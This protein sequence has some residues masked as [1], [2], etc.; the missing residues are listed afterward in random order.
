MH[1]FIR[2]SQ[3]ALIPHTK[4]SL[5]TLSLVIHAQPTHGTTLLEAINVQ[6]ASVTLDTRAILEG[7][8]NAKVRQV[9][10]LTL[11]SCFRFRKIS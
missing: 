1:A 2:L 8:L 3:Y 5:V 10:S 9:F 11:I 7:M 6:I 4:T